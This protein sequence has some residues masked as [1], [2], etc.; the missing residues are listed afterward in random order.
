MVS[1]VHAFRGYRFTISDR[2]GSIFE[3]ALENVKDVWGCGTE[4]QKTILWQCSLGA[5]TKHSEWPRGKM[6]ILADPPR[7]SDGLLLKPWS[8]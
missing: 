8:G 7:S 6:S 1:E 2:G 3:V 4:E 5:V